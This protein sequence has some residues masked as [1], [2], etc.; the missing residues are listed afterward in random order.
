[1][2]V[3]S[4]GGVQ[5]LEGLL[6]F[7]GCFSGRFPIAQTVQDGNIL[8]HVNRLFQQPLRGKEMEAECW[9]DGKL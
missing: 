3:S 7:L 9:R 1:M 5:L 8:L 6:C 2:D 4:E